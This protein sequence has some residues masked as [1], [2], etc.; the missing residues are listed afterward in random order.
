VLAGFGLISNTHPIFLENKLAAC[1]CFI[2]FLVILR[3]T[4]N[5][6]ERK[7][8]PCDSSALPQTKLSWEK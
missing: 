6:R 3:K 1:F 8:V 7:C 4:E 2:V 5:L